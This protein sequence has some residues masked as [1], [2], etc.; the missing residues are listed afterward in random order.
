VINQADSVRLFT[1]EQEIWKRGY[2]HIAGIDEAGRGALAGPVVAAAVKFGREVFLP[3]LNDSKQVSP[4]LRERLFTLILEEA[5]DY[6]IGIVDEEVIDHQNIW[7]ATKLAI[8]L[9]LKECS[10]PL[11]YLL[12]DGVKVPEFVLPQLPLPKGDQLSASIAAASILAKVT[13]D[14]IMV[15]FD[16]EFPHY[17]F[18]KH[19]GYGTKEHRDRIQR[20][21]P[22]RI[23]RKTFRGVREYAGEQAR[24]REKR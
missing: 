10:T 20:F 4:F 18:A 14:R 13:R 21:G 5:D 23:H 9:A 1:F 16:K 24:D 12:I 11:E 8:S 2:H 3:G 22:C 7:I 17:L 15:E 6:G 19:K